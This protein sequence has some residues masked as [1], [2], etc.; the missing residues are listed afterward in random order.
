MG[1]MDNE[2]E[3]SGWS[4]NGPRGRLATPFDSNFTGAG[5][6]LPSRLVRIQHLPWLSLWES[7]LRAEK[8]SEHTIRAYLSAARRFVSILLPDEK[9]I[10]I[11]NMPISVMHDRCDP[12]NGRL[13]LFVQSISN[14]RPSTINARIAAIGHLFKYLGHR[15]PDWVQRPSGSRP[16]PR[17]LT[18]D[19]IERVRISAENS[20]NPL[21]KPIITLLLDT[22]MRVSEVCALDMNNLDIKDKSARIYGGK[23][24]KDRLVLFTQKT[25]T[26]MEA[27]FGSRRMQIEAIKPNGNDI[28]AVFL[29]TRSG[30]IGPRYIQKMMDAIADSAG[31]PRT[32][33]TPHTLRHN[34]ATGLLERGVDL[35]SIQRL[36]GHSNIQTTRIYLDISDQTLR[37]IYHRAQSAAI[38]E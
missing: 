2:R 34:F 31:I 33:L 7:Q 6:V 30:R 24:N 37:E 3:R 9:E 32:R 20:E 28:D 5:Q 11:E 16:L 18:R 19:E 17:T 25:V 35:V 12:N 4:P 10:E 13:D 14:L 15:I 21:A 26:S 8:K 1:P 27:W 23:G 22:G 38:E 36:L 29:S